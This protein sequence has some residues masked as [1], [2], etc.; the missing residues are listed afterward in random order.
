HETPRM[1]DHGLSRVESQIAR[2]V[3]AAAMSVGKPSGHWRADAMRRSAA[4]AAMP[5]AAS[6]PPGVSTSGTVGGAMVPCNA[7]RCVHRSTT[8]VS[9]IETTEAPKNSLSHV[10]RG[11]RCVANTTRFAGLD[12]GKTKLAA[13]AM[14]AQIKRYGIGLAPAC[15]VAAYTAGVSTTAV[16]S[17]DRRTVTRTPT[18]YTRLKS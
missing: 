18:A 1:A 12:I 16:A 11:G 3:A 7:E 8:N 14:K 17:L 6:L 15:R 13:L 10:A 2:A 4:V 9:R 5:A